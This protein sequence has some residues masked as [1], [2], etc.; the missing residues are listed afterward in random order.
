[1]ATATGTDADRPLISLI[2]TVRD[3]AAYLA[4]ALASV[5]AQTFQDWELVLWDDG[6]TDETLSI[7]RSFASDDSRIRLVSQPPIGRRR[8]LAEA[9]R[10]ARGTYLGWLDADDWLAPEA[11]ARAYAAITSSRC[12]MV[13][14]EHVVVGADGEHRG[15]RRCARIPY[16]AHRLLLDFMTFHFRLFSR[17]VFDRAGGIDPDREI[18]IDYDLCLRISEHGRI[19]HLAEPLYFYRVHD[20]QM[21]SRHRAAQ[22]AAS[23]AAINAAL[24]RRALTGYELVVDLER[25]RF[26]LA[27]RPPRIGR[28][29]LALATAFPRFRRNEPMGAPSLIG[30]WPAVGRYP[31]PDADVARGAQLLPLGRDLASLMRAVWT[32]RAGD[33]LRIHGIAPLLEA[34]ADGSVLGACLLFVKT[35]DHAL[36]RRMRVVWVSTGPLTTHAQHAAREQWCRRA[37]STRCHGVV[38]SCRADVETFRELGVPDDRIVVAPELSV[39]ELRPSANLIQRRPVPGTLPLSIVIPIRNRAGADVRNALAS[40]AWQR[41]GRPWETILVSHGSDPTIDAELRELAIAVGATLITVGT[42]ADAWCKPLALNT[43]ILATDPAIPFVMAMDGDMILGENMLETVV[44]ELRDDPQKVVLCQSSDLPEDCAIPDEPDAI[45][46]QFAQLR[47]RATVRGKF[48]TGGIQAMKRSFLVEVRGYDEDMLWWG[49]LD[50]DLVRRA[51]AAGLHASWVTDR[52]AMLHQWH[53]RKHHI[54]DESSRAQAA[55]GS[56]QRNHELMYERR[57][58]VVR[59]HRGWGAAINIE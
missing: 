59:N 29:Q 10:Q 46:A 12:D 32:G 45:R 56:W 50:T 34:K 38:T 53:P 20:E 42:P 7:A 37:F 51:E 41:G 11:L 52:T 24:V 9:H 2:T 3:G 18:A 55:R 30:Q 27:H 16:S 36:A 58:H 44:A 8:A 43:G 54:L 25:G 40:L 47:A 19:E 21:S 15:T 48:G 35:L 33:T 1:M 28:L 26:R 17:D 13:Y 39:T 5:R 6:S 31:E 23:A 49:A 57:G 22:I 14:T 4:Q